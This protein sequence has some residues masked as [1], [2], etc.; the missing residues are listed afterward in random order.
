RRRGRPAERREPLHGDVRE[1]PAPAGA[2]LLVA[3]AVRR[4]PLLRA[5]RAEALLARHQEQDP[6]AR[7]RRRAYAL[8]PGRLA[9]R[10][11][12]VEL[13]ARAEGRR[14]LAVRAR[15]LARARDHAGQVDAPT[16]AEGVV[17]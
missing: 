9:G 8:R 3:H 14:L 1:G 12:G 4:A 10:G 6:E 5:E 17:E 7:S 11:Q 2:R 13:A 15:L 16:R